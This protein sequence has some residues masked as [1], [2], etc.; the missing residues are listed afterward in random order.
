[1]RCD[2]DSFRQV[3]RVDSRGVHYRVLSRPKIRL[4]PRSSLSMANRDRVSRWAL[5]GALVALI[6]V[7]DYVDAAHVYQQFGIPS[8]F[9]GWA[10]FQSCLAAGPACILLGKLALRDIRRHPGLRGELLAQLVVI[11]GWLGLLGTIVPIAW[12]ATVLYLGVDA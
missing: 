11:A 6:G 8:E 2:W 4:Q 12:I 7:D 3:P 10:F 5:A 9:A 1:M